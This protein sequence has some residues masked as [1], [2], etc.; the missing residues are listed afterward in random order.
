MFLE[1]Y[2]LL[3]ILNNNAIYAIDV[4]AAIDFIHVEVS[5]NKWQILT[6]KYVLKS[7]DD[8]ILF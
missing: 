1:T 8:I 4:L 2:R 5:N 7:F 3:N 6:Q